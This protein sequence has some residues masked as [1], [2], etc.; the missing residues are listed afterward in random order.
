MTYH[1]RVHSRE[2]VDRREVDRQAKLISLYNQLHNT[3]YDLSSVGIELVRR[4]QPNDYVYAKPDVNFGWHNRTGT[5][6]STHYTE[7]EK[8]KLQGR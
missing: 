5:P 1:K 2:V 8:K 7:E 4:V 3:S 6:Y